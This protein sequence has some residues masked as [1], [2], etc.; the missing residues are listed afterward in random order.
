[1]YDIVIKNGTVVDGKN[2]KRF[3]ADVGIK[4]GVIQAVG[5]RLSGKNEFGAEGLIV[6]PGFID[7]HSHTD[8]VLVNSL[9]FESKLRQG[10]TTEVV[11]N[12]GF[13]IAPVINKSSFEAINQLVSGTVKKDQFR[14]NFKSTYPAMEKRGLINN[15][16]TFSG[17][18]VLRAAVMGFDR[19]RPSYNELEKMKRLLR[20]ALKEGAFGISSGL[21]YPPGFYSET[22]ELVELAKV[23]ADQGGFYVSH[24]RG[25]SNTL[26]FAVKEALDIGRLSGANVHISH[27]KCM[28]HSAWNKSKKV[29]S[30]ME[31]ALT[32]GVRV[33]ADQYPYTASA[34]VLTALLSSWTCE[35]GNVVKILADKKLRAKISAQMDKGE[36]LINGVAP[37]NVFISSCSNRS[38]EGRHIAEIANEKKLLPNETVFRIIEEDVKTNMVFHGIQEKDLLEFLKYKRVCIGTDGS[39]YNATGEHTDKPH[40]RNFGTF[41][42]VLGHY[43]REKKVLSL[44]EAI[45]KMSYLPSLIMGIMDRGSIDEG[46]KA[47]I[48]V[49]NAGKVADTSTF[50]EPFSYPE[51]IR[52]VFVNGK[53]AFNGRKV[54]G[55]FGKYLTRN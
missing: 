15:I 30:M 48:T 36:A 41:P 51:G 11:G 12:C 6:C 25:E 46:K 28:G 8:I 53:Q 2:T 44:E 55:A 18:G 52:Q 13:S 33:T 1:M 21:I 34:T 17:H 26:L 5:K 20:Q 31:E 49:F 14:P 39:A 19:R 16:A 45:Y 23:A 32:Q 38:Y 54:T 7:T 43:V 22:K 27:I 42:R 50:A 9:K 4:N 35:G 10:V 24:I 29:I 47:D 37:E 40:P 3:V